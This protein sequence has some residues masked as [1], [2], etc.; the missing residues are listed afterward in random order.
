MTPEELEDAIKLLK[1]GYIYEIGIIQGLGAAMID[2]ILNGTPIP[3]N[4]I[5]ERQVL[6]DA[7]DTDI[8]SLQNTGK[9][10]NNDKKKS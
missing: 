1:E 10:V 5:D 7:C 4:I 2:Y 9:L 6:L 8:I 3:Q